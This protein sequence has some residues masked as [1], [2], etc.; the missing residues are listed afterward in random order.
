[1]GSVTVRYFC[2]GCLFT[3]ATWTVLLF[4]YFNFSEVTQPL[5]NVP[6][7]G[8]GPHGP[9]P[10]KFYPR[11]TRGPS[12]VLES[13]FKVNKIDDMRDNNHIEDSEKDNVKFSSELVELVFHDQTLGNAVTR[14]SF[15]EKRLKIWYRKE[16]AKGDFIVL[17]KGKIS[18]RIWEQGC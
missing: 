11:F 9:F 17:G 8:S 5:R 12:R 10:K 16:K 7:K 15:C 4:V 1:M 13:Q 14:E 18:D 2:Y 3:S 6:I